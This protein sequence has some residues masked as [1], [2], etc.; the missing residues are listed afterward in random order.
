MLQQVTEVACPYITNC[1]KHS[2]NDAIFPTELKKADVTS[3]F[4][5]WEKTKRK[6]FRPISI[7]PCVST[8]YG[9][10]FGDQLNDDFISRNNILCNLLSGFRKGY[11]TQHV[12]Q[13]VIKNWKR[14][15]ASKII[16]GTI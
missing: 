2:I 6:D 11:S 14:S 13:V 9:R 8:I 3:L 1:I 15:V 7:L 16:V 12:L 5:S 4:K 10:L